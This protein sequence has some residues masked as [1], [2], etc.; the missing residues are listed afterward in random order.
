MPEIVTQECKRRNSEKFNKLPP[1][2]FDFFRY[3][4]SL[5]W[6]FFRWT[7]FNPATPLQVESIP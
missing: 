3:Y 2:R 5:S 6:N 7:S 4:F 1:N